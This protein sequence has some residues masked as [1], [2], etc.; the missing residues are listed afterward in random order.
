MGNYF[1]VF[2]DSEGKHLMTAIKSETIVP[3]GGTTKFTA[4]IKNI[5]MY[6]MIDMTLLCN[7]KEVSFDPRT[8]PFIGRGQIVPITITWSPSVSRTQPL[9]ATISADFSIVKRVK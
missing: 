4:F 6:D 7:D 3:A 1:E 5:S 8:I 2:S 9:N